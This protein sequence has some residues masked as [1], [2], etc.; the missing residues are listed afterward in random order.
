MT[1]KELRRERGYSI[2]DLASKTNISRQSIYKIETGVCLP[3]ITTVIALSQAL[4]VSVEQLLKC[5]EK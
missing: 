4:D 1:F 2:K 5:F 3:K